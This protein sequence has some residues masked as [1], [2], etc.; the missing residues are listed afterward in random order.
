[1]QLR[2]VVVWLLLLASTSLMAQQTEQ[3]DTLLPKKEKFE[4]NFLMSYYQQDGEHSPVTGGVGTEELTNTAPSISMN[5]PLSEKH[6]VSFSGGIDYYTSASSDNIDNP[7]LITDYI[8]GASSADTR[9]YADFGYTYKKKRSDYGLSF[10]F[11]SEYDVSS[12]SAGLSYGLLSKDENRSLQLS[13]G[14]FRDNWK[15][16]YPVELRNGSVQYLSDDIRQSLNFGLVFTSVLTKRIQASLSAD[17]V[18]QQGLLSTPFHRVYF[19][20]EPLA[21]VETA[22]DSRFKVPVGLRMNVF[23]T[24]F[25]ILKGFYRYY[26][27]DFEIQSHTFKIDMPVILTHWLRVYPQYR[28]YTQTEAFHF[29]PYFEAD[30]LAEFYTSD[31]DLSAFSSHMYSLGLQVKPLFGFARIKN[32]FND[33][34]VVLF[35]SIDLKYSMYSRSDGLEASIVTLGVN[36]KSN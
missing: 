18:Y 14:Y 24:D 9:G 11:S 2:A 33:K 15:L 26:W 25:L 4:V 35:E 13:A 21:R 22:P 8:S 12:L 27:D 6:V 29:V 16:I 20:G 32:P 5:I 1:M 10:G 17:L 30:P 3:A 34:K 28:Y 7:D 36:F 31:Y 19:A 23:V